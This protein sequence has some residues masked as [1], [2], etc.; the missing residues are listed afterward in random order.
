VAYL[1]RERTGANLHAAPFRPLRN[2]GG[3]RRLRFVRGDRRLLHH[4]PQHVAALRADPPVAAGGAHLVAARGKILRKMACGAPAKRRAEA[5]VARLVAR[6]RVVNARVLRQRRAPLPPPVDGQY[7]EQRPAAARDQ[8][9]QA[10]EPRA[11]HE[12]EEGGGRDPVAA[13][14]IHLLH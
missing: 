2:Q 13:P 5:L 10:V 8:P 1:E 12:I 7:R 11:R 9:A 4:L 14:E 6:E 3:R